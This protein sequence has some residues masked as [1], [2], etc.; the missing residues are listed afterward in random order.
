V[1]GI[2]VIQVRGS[3]LLL[4]DEPARLYS[5]GKS[6]R[7]QLNMRKQAKAAYSGGMSQGN[8]KRLAKAVTIMS[9]AIKPVWITNPVTKRL[10]YHKFSFITLTVANSENFTARQG[11][12]L[13][14]NHFL[15]WMTRTVGAENPAAKTYIWKAELQKR[16][17]IHYHITTPAFIHW[18]LIRNKWNELQH[19]AGL[20][21]DYAKEHGHF[22]P[23]GT[24]VHDTRSVKHADRYLLKELGKTVSAVQLEAMRELKAKLK[25][26]E[27]TADEY[28]EQ[29]EAIKAEKWKTVGKV[30]GCSQDLAGVNYF[31]L[32]VTR[33]HENLIEQWIQEGRARKVSDDYFSIVYCDDVDP[34]DLLTP[35]ETT[36]F[37]DYLKRSIERTTTQEM[38]PEAVP[39]ACVQM[40]LVEVCTEYH[41][42]QLAINFN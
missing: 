19:K 40:E 3:S 8:R 15:D 16:G 6:V 38:Q 28:R 24:D 30:W 14:L 41:F 17:Q 7:R 42:E 4:Y 31:T 27:V 22:D 23:N 2:P 18:R 34:P 29:L 5:F 1:T 37:K 20:L 39:A 36:R 25:D 9:Q 21:D 32:E 35:S 33:A 11:Y 26:Q 13:L 12:D 10:H